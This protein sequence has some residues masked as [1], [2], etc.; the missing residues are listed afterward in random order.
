MSTFS[1]LGDNEQNQ[2]NLQYYV[3]LV[4]MDTFQVFQTEY[5][6]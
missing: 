1:S 2:P 6:A 3:K 5:K 4:E